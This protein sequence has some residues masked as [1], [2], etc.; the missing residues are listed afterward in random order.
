MAQPD[1]R[2]IAEEFARWARGELGSSIVRVVLFG[3]VARGED[4][5]GSDIDVLV[6]VRG[7][8]VP[9]R[10]RLGGKIMEIAAKEG[11]FVSAFVQTAE[12][13]APRARYGIYRVIDTE[14]RVL[15]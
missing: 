3:S 2:R 1:R 13:D 8:P 15:A 5:E 12:G 11:V 9:V 7:N 4:R 10:R 14:G 6:E